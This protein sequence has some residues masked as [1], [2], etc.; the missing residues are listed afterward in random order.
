MRSFK[1][2]SAAILFLVL[3]PGCTGHYY[4]VPSPEANPA[5]YQNL[6]PVTQTATGVHLF[7]IFPIMLNDKI[8][9]AIE[10][11]IAQKGGDAITNLTIRERW[12]WAYVL[13]IYKVDVEGDVLK[14]R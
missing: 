13:N 7:G 2:A 12:Y 10:H 6:G 8:E 4:K 5:Q 1:L 14:K 9:R 3:L 11:A